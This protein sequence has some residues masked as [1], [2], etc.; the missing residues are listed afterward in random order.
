MATLSKGSAGHEVERIQQFL[1]LLASGEF[2][3]ETQ[4]AVRS[5]QGAHGLAAD[6]VV[7]KETWAALV[8]A[9][10]LDPR[11]IVPAAPAILGHAGRLARFGGPEFSWVDAPTPS[12]P[13]GVHISGAWR[14]QNLRQIQVTD[15][16]GTK[17]FPSS[18][19][20]TLHRL[21]VDPFRALVDAW[22]SAGLLGLILTWDGSWSPRYVRGSRKSLS[23]HAFGTAFDLN[24]RW[25][26]LGQVPAAVGAEGTVRPL[27]DVAI[28][29]GWAWGGD[30]RGR[31]DGMHFEL[32]AD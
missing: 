26:G 11:P 28:R 29:R 9:G 13:E 25:N 31:P 10:M 20:I 14:L 18:A 15:L 8:A 19:T 5:W 27:A 32:L 2:G 30:Y 1:G 24:A 7:G 4:A 6:G 23:S 21:A 3:V 16:A 17:G 12:N 22:R